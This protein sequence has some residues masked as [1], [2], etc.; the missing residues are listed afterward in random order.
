MTMTTNWR[1]IAAMTT[2]KKKKSLKMRKPKTRKQ[3][4]PVAQ[5]AQI[6]AKRDRTLFLTSFLALM[7]ILA[8]PPGTSR[9]N[10][11]IVR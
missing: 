4:A 11:K 6:L 9:F 3:D 8:I 1:K 10:M 2:K 5:Q 7:P